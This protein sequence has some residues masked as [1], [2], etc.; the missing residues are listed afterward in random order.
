MKTPYFRIALQAPPALLVVEI[1]A[2]LV[3][4]P[5]LPD[6]HHHHHQKKAK[7]IGNFQLAKE[8]QNITDSYQLNQHPH[9]VDKF[10]PVSVQDPCQFDQL[11][12]RP[13]CVW[14]N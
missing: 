12:S 1:M 9:I 2:M 11:T 6:H 5:H 3:M 4:F 7:L 14:D 10:L 13:L 8:S